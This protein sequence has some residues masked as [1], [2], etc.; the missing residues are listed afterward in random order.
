MGFHV[1]EAESILAAQ[2]MI[3]SGTEDLSLVMLDLY[4]PH[5]NG[6]KLL[7]EI[8]RSLRTQTLPV[9]ILTGSPNPRDEIELLEGGET[10]SY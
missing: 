3:E 9:M 1:V 4:M 10:T 6:T 5:G 8:R 2:Q 7:K